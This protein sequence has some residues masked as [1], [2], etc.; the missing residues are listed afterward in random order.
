MQVK[1]KVNESRI[2]LIR[3]G[4]PV[5]INVGAAANELLGRVIKVNKYAEPGNW[6]GTSAKE[7]AVFVQILNPPEEIR[8]GMTAE[9]R[10]FVE[11]IPEAL[12]LPVHAVYESKK[13]HYVLVKSGDNWTTNPIKLGATNEKFVTVTSGL[14]KGDSV[15]LDPRRH[16]DLMDIPNIEEVDDRDALAKIAA[17]APKGRSI[18]TGS[19]SGADGPSGG[20]PGNGGFGGGAGGPPNADTIV[21]AIFGRLDKDNDGKLSKQE[22][23]GDERMSA[24]FAD[25][26][27]N[28]DGSVDK[29]E[30]TAGMRKR[31]AAGGGGGGGP[32]GGSSRGA[33][34]N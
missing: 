4:M 30:M 16:L 17:E 8:T 5:K 14:A 3:E 6:F 11:Q 25:S 15:A 22:V 29:A 12:Q 33:P 28:K 2:T 26:D 13:H 7:Y 23:A 31:M 32:G 10:I 27:T 9:T 19:R 24:G 20:G 34:S 18:D 1:A 21:A